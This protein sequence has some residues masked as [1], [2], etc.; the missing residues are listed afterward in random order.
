MASPLSL[1]SLLLLLTL[2]ASTWVDATDQTA[3]GFS[4]SPTK[5]PSSSSSSS[6]G[7]QQLLEDSTGIFSFGF[8]RVGIHD[9][10]L[11]VVHVP[12]SLPLW[13]AL[14]NRDDVHV[15]WKSSISLNFHGSLELSDNASGTLYWSSSQLGNGSRLRL[16]NTSNL[17]ITAGEGGGVTSVVW[18]SFD[19]PSET[20]VQDQ[21]FT[22]K[23]QLHSRNNRFSMRLG[24]N[25][26]G[27]YYDNSSVMYWKQTALEARADIIDGEGPIYARIN[28]SGGYLGIYQKEGQPADVMPFDSFNR[29]VSV[30]FRLLTVDDDGD[31]K[32]HYW[33]GSSWVLD[34]NA[35]SHMC[36]LPASCGA[37]GLCHRQD[38]NGS[39]SCLDGN[40]TTTAFNTCLSEDTGDLCFGGR[41]NSNNNYFVVRRRGVNLSY[42]ELI[43]F[44]KTA[45]LEE[46]EASCEQN[47][48][49]W[50]ALYSDS[51]GYCY[52]M[53]F[54]IETLVEEKGQGKAGYFKVRTTNH[55]PTNRKNKKLKNKN[56]ILHLALLGIGILFFGACIGFGIL[57]LITLCKERKVS[58]R[59]IG[60]D[61]LM[62]DEG[63]S[64]VPYRDLK[65]SSNHSS[66][67]SV[68]LS[69]TSTSPFK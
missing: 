22:S 46:C 45:T 55:V 42:K 13:R 62:L 56:F 23:A 36:D 38:S 21:N 7:F 66:F 58:N 15:T 53:D 63:L 40:T 65:S 5:I 30:L 44:T 32:G 25:Y 59:L 3:T 11:A 17:Q 28:S 31:L 50:G 69:T 4:A 18:Q 27:L 60:E 12:S 16:L 33:N 20:I 52:Q 9:L 49:C 1:F 67:T 47:C 14:G 29:N 57:K 19:Y 8:L 24:P 39:C 61:R 37:Y 48:T 68:E 10:D 35:I 2:F 43:G 26:L 34:F 64:P 54:P 41:D 6:F 51:S